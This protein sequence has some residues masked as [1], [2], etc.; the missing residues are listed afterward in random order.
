MA[1]Q[2]VVLRN[3][4]RKDLVE[5]HKTKRKALKAMISSPSSSY[6][7]KQ[8]AVAA[9]S[10]LPRDSSPVRLRFRC[11]ITGRP[12]GYYRRFGLSRHKLR[13]Y[14]MNGG[15]PGIRKASW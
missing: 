8:K 13:E 11:L 6:D 2:S 5:K 9:L 3:Q 10:A 4:K 7:E 14:A 15:I 1:K 12:R